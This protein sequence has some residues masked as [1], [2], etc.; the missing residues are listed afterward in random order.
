MTLS[1][2]C[3]SIMAAPYKTMAEKLETMELKPNAIIEGEIIYHK[4]QLFIL[5]NFKVIYPE[6]PKIIGNPLNYEDFTKNN[7]TNPSACGD[8]PAEVIKAA[9]GKGSSPFGES[10]NLKNGN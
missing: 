1:D 8:I 4:K 3:L 7:Y 6:V 5:L 2:G 10:P 9:G